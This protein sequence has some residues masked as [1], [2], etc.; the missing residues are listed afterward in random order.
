MKIPFMNQ[1]L[2][3]VMAIAVA[4][5]SM[6]GTTAGIE[7]AVFFE[8]KI[9]LNTEALL[10]MA[11]SADAEVPE[12]TLQ[13]LKAAGDI[14]NVLTL[15][16]TATKDAAQLDLL[17]GDDTA[18]SVG[19]KSEE[20]GVTVASS[21]LGSNT[22][23]VSAELIDKQRGLTGISAA[24][25]TDLQA[26]AVK[27][28]DIDREQLAKDCEEA[29]G[30]LKQAIEDQ[31]G[32]TE[33]GE[34]IV[35]GKTY[36][37]ITHVNMSYIEFTEL[38]LTAVKELAERDSV[39]PLLA[40]N[41]L[42]PEDIDKA[43]TELK[44]QPESD[45][46]EY[47]D[48]RIYTDADSNAYYVCDM[49]NKT[50]T[51]GAAEERLHIGYG[52]TAGFMLA[53]IQG[54]DKMLISAS[55]DPEGA[56]DS[57]VTIVNSRMNI[58]FSGSRNEAGEMDMTCT[59]KGMEPDMKIDVHTKPAEAERTDFQIML[60]AGVASL[61]MITF[62]GSAGKGG[63]ITSTFEGE[64]ITAIPIENLMESEN[65]ILS[66][67]VQMQIAAGLLKSIVV[68]SKNL[69]ADTAEW[70]N[71]QIRNAMTPKTTKAPQGEPVVD[72]E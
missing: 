21:M 50:G 28:L 16:G 30:K 71:T 2:S 57:Y 42:K 70:L 14:L 65:E 49:T 72:G 7:D 62:S 3:A 51:I 10:D 8:T 45:Y 48:L 18:L 60:Y 15:R 58:E 5:A 31:K 43:I 20:K 13:T 44:N 34:F 32:E 55:G 6:G 37:G 29:V 27:P 25:G 69:P 17:A 61:P 56:M 11:A 40:A 38:C 68:L 53:R 63:E 19:M 35:D 26:A 22:I 59:I 67:Q 41:G 24:T 64:K 36:T 66:S 39:K 54:E 1:I 12:N 4:F 9:S 33:T 46:P 23:F 52:D 47:F